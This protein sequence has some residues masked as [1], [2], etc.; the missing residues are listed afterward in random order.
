[1]FTASA[2]IV[3]LTKFP[4]WNPIEIIL[5][6]SARIRAI[7][8]HYLLPFLAMRTDI[9]ESID[10]IGNVMGHLVVNCLRE[11][12][13]KV[14]GKYE[15]VVAN[16]PLPISDP[17]HPRGPTAKIKQHRDFSKFPI[18]QLGRLLNSVPGFLYNQVSI[19]VSN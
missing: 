3:V 19:K 16:H 18:V 13:I 12:V 6:G 2:L 7:E 8:P 1:M 9:P 15:R 17:V 11:V 10:N 5:A 14:L 4:R